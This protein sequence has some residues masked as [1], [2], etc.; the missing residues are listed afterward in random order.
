VASFSKSFD[1]LLEILGT[2][3]SDLKERH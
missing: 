2:K 1:E 3:A